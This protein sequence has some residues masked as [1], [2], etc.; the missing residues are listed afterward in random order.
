MMH[1]QAVKIL[2]TMQPVTTQT[3]TMQ[4]IDVALLY[5]NL[6]IDARAALASATDALEVDDYRRSG[7]EWGMIRRAVATVN[8]MI[9]ERDRAAD[10]RYRSGQP[11]TEPK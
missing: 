5:T 10:L 8:A 4:D 11:W 1:S 3:I 6:G 7:A 9:A 2:A